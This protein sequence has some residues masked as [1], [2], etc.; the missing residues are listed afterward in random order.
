MVNHPNRSKRPFSEMLSVAELA[1]GGGMLFS[2][3]C[4]RLLRSRPDPEE[5]VTISVITLQNILRGAV[6]QI[7]GGR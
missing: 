6:R 4:S 5:V 1:I 2:Q 3:A 7:D